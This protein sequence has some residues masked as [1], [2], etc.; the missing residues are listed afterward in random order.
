MYVTGRVSRVWLTL[1]AVSV[2]VAAC[3]GTSPSAAPVRTP[4]I[5]QAQNVGLQAQV[6]SSDLAVGSNRFTFGIINNNHPLSTGAPQLSFYYLKGNSATL[7]STAVAHFSNFARGLR[8]TAANSAA[9]EIKGVYVA[10]ATFTRPGKWG[11][12]VRLPWH[13][14]VVVLRQEFQVRSHSLTPAVGS[15]APRSNNPTIAQEPASKLDSG[16]PPDDM[17]KL[18]I[19]QAIAQHRPLIVLFSTPGFCTS[20]MCGPETQAVE[21]LEQQYRS[22]VNFIHIEIYKDANPAHGFAPTVLQWHL[23]TEPWVFVINRQGIITAKFEGPTPGTE[24]V[25][26]INAALHT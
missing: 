22:R 9:I 17:H 5:S 7:M 4:V 19:A 14:K 6:A 15:P 13:G 12:Q 3:G 16:K 18:S 2:L 21:K 11:A 23:Q 24:I 20:R 8:D 26:A 10:R 1:S 25:P